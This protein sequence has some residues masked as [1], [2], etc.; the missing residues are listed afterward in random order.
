MASSVRSRSS[1]VQEMYEPRAAKRAGNGIHEDEDK[2][3][4]A[5]SI[6]LNRTRA[7]DR[8]QRAARSATAML[9]ATDPGR[10][11]GLLADRKE[12]ELEALVEQKLERGDLAPLVRFVFEGQ[13]LATGTQS[14]PGGRQAGL[15]MIQ[16]A[17][18]KV[19][20]H[21]K[22]V[23]TDWCSRNAVQMQSALHAVTELQERAG[24]MEGELQESQQQLAKAGKKLVENISELQAAVK[25]ASNVSLA[26]S[27]VEEVRRIVAQ[28]VRAARYVQSG[29]LHLAL[30]IVNELRDT[31]DLLALYPIPAKEKHAV[32][33]E[34]SQ[35]EYDLVIVIIKAVQSL[36]RA[37]RQ[38]ERRTL[39]DWLTATRSAAA[40]VGERA[41]RRA[42]GERAHEDRLS[43]ERKM[44]LGML[45][46]DKDLK[47]AKALVLHFIAQEDPAYGRSSIK[48][49]ASAA[50]MPIDFSLPKFSGSKKQRFKKPSMRAGR[51]VDSDEA[52]NALS[53]LEDIDMSCL[54]RSLHVQEM[55]GDMDT[56]REYYFEQRHLQLSSDLTPPAS[57]LESH[58]QYL[59]H[60]TG[61][62][63]IE[64][65]VLQ[66]TR[67]LLTDARLNTLWVAAVAAMKT[68]I[69]AGFSETDNTAAQLVLKD[70]TFLTASAL[71]RHRYDTAPILA[72]LSQ[73]RDRYH[74]S[75]NQEAALSIRAALRRELKPVRIESAEQLETLITATG[76]PAELESPDTPALPFA[77]PFSSALPAIIGIV[78]SYVIDSLQFLQGLL[79]SHELL[80]TV[81]AHRDRFL[82]RL[83]TDLYLHHAASLLRD[84]AHVLNFILMAGDAASLAR[85]LESLDEWTIVAMRGSE[86]HAEE[87]LA[88]MARTLRRTESLQGRG[89]GTDVAEVSQSADAVAIL[90]QVVAQM[91]EQLDTFVYKALG[92]TVSSIAKG[93]AKSNWF[94]EAPLSDSVSPY[95]EQLVTMLQDCFDVARTSLPARACSAFVQRAFGMA[96]AELVNFIRD[97]E[98]KCWNIHGVQRFATDIDALSALAARNEHGAAFADLD[99]MCA[100]LSRQEWG[101]A[102]QPE[103][104]MQAFPDMD[105]LLLV[106]AMRKFEPVK[107]KY[108][109]RI[110]SKKDKQ[111]TRGEVQALAKGIEQAVSIGR[112]RASAAQ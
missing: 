63:I 53:L 9:N 8:F 51:A 76:L 65:K 36:L 64:D 16:A 58:R 79:H 6:S 20:T 66:S 17:L 47:K 80:A 86:E 74:D 3:D 28:L 23:I 24:R 40:V 100:L 96:H 49:K 42:A 82:A 55:L 84:G 2:Q 94:P 29:E 44:L 112:I 11:K 26:H 54:H 7:R 88:L 59:M 67:G 71:A 97:P 60:I 70:Y 32:L 52:A 15:A 68:C 91:Q 45:I 1:G 14:E 81:R 57:M 41:V 95:M 85:T 72:C 105:A 110:R 10:R 25:V 109:D 101:L 61:F 56:F 89:S 90:M 13:G 93:A 87:D 21:E 37:V 108:Q 77:A 34:M 99:A 69:D 104:M 43:Q 103:Q 98:F 46:K 62:F 107:A 38:H 78:E 31:S 92:Q 111:V 75:L 22:A 106:A 4:D 19:M 33:A 30:A 48:Q 27:A 5:P 12:A 50:E 83:L 18:T 102:E 39:H 73:Y 35:G